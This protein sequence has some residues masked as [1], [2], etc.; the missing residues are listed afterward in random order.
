MRI[1]SSIILHNGYCFQSYEWKFFRPLGALK[2]VL[3]FLDKYDVDEICITRPIRGID[4]EKSFEED[5]KQI[6]SSFSNSPIGFGGGLR[7]KENLKFLNNLPI[8]RIHLSD[9]FLYK[10]MGVIDGI[11]NTYGKQAL[12]AT[13]PLKLQD[14]DLYVFHGR[15]NSFEILTSNTINLIDEYADELMIIDVENEGV[16]NTFNFKILDQLLLSN[17]RIIICGGI[18]PKVVKHAKQLGIASCMIDNRVL[19]NENYLKREL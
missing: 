5:L 10:N 11:L 19:H 15:K 3:K 4:S 12:V 2:N 16:N 13:L 17:D 14:N 6:Q 1:G 7:S 9:A 18:G 8:E